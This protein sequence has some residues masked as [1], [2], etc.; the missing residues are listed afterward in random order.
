[1]HIQASKTLSDPR[2]H[3]YRRVF[4]GFV[5]LIIEQGEIA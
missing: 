1:M 4:A 5:G 2:A 3:I